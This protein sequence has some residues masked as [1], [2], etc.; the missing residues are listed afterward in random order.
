MYVCGHLPHVIIFKLSF[1]SALNNKKVATFL[2]KIIS[3]MPIL[4][5]LYTVDQLFWSMCSNSSFHVFFVF[6]AFLCV[7]F[8]LS[9]I[10]IDQFMEVRTFLWYSFC[11][12]L[13]TICLSSYVTVWQKIWFTIS[14]FPFFYCTFD[15]WCTWKGWKIWLNEG[16]LQVLEKLS[17]WE[18]KGNEK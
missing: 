6:I 5:Y 1:M 12:F 3:A 16:V 9:I 14:T 15:I 10:L 18:I 7:Y 13:F 17:K 4:N 8:Y 11:N 2:C